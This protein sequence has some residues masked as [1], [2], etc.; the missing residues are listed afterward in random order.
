MI[1][2]EKGDRET[3]FLRKICIEMSSVQSEILGNESKACAHLT[4]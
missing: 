3:S 1:N 2:H 4:F